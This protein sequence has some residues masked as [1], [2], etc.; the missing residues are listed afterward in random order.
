MANSFGH[1]PWAAALVQ[2][3]RS[4]GDSTQKHRVDKY[5]VDEQGKSNWDTPS[6]QKTA[7]IVG[8]VIGVLFRFSLP[9]SLIA[10]A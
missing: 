5:R 1:T 2:L 3:A 9:I 10:Y 7:T 4:T 6:T 8:T